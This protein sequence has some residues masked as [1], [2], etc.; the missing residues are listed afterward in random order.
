MFSLG[1][2]E[3]GSPYIVSGIYFSKLFLLLI[4]QQDLGHFYKHRLLLSIDWRFSLIVCQRQR[5]L[6]KTTPP[7]SLRDIVG[8]AK[9]S[10][11]ICEYVKRLD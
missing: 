3:K 4:G 5:T 11:I 10:F 1:K 8:Q 7:P 9:S 6:T 2:I